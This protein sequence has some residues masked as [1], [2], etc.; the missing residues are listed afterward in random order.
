VAER[1]VLQ[2]VRS[3][4]RIYEAV[5]QR[6]AAPSVRELAR[7]LS[8]NKSTVHR[9]LVTLEESG[10]LRI[11]DRG[12]WVITARAFSLGRRAADQGHL[13]SAVMPIMEQLREETQESIH[14]M[15]PEGRDVVLM[16][17]LESPQTVRTFFIV[18]ARGPLH[19]TANGKSILAYYDDAALE[20]YLAGGLESRAPRTQ[21]D[22]AALRAELADIRERGWAIAVDEASDGASA[23]AAAILDPLERPIASLSISVPTSRFGANEH[24]RYGKLVMEAAQEASRRVFGH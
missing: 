18:G 6:K 12:L 20:Q 17:R 9:C 15:M 2:S 11:D 3:A 24:L 19:S 22:P 7:E 21:T 16:G 1:E 23:V 8:L 10:W 14:L 4:I 13:R 5:A